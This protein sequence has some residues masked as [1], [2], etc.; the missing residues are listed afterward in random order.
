[1]LIVGYWVIV[2]LRNIGHDVVV[3]L[4]SSAMVVVS[5]W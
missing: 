3:S 4:S 5:H 2:I 1:M